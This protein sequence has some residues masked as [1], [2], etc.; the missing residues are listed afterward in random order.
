[1]RFSWFRRIATQANREGQAI[2]VPARVSRAFDYQQEDM[3][4]TF[5]HLPQDQDCDH[6]IWNALPQKQR[7]EECF[8]NRLNIMSEC[9]ECGVRVCDVCLARFLRQLEQNS[10][11]T[12][13]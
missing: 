9:S 7:C 6:T 12:V 11:R 8:E 2:P 3:Q 5:S 13:R 1:M 10:G 4:E